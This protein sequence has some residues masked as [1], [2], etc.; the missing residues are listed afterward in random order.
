MS[1]YTFIIAFPLIIFFAILWIT[2]KALK[3]EETV[4]KTS[5]KR[6]KRDSQKI[7]V[8]CLLANAQITVDGLE[9]ITISKNHKKEIFIPQTYQEIKVFVKSGMISDEYIIR[10]TNAIQE[11]IF[12]IHSLETKCTVQYKNSSVPVP[13]MPAGDPNTRWLKQIIIIIIVIVFGLFGILLGSRISAM[14]SVIA[15]S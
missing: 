7:T 12:I 10:N 8:S 11:I 6:K 9:T 2:Y 13:I 15:S 14:I 5:Q 4:T 3:Y 1:Y